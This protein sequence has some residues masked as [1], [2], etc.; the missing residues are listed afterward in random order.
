MM[1]SVV[2]VVVM[3]VMLLLWMDETRRWCWIDDLMLWLW[4]WW[5]EMMESPR[6]SEQQ[7]VLLDHVG[8]LAVM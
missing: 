1:L 4:L 7:H 6:D 2:V 8:S 3:V 5:N